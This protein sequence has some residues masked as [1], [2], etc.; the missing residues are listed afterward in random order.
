MFSNRINLHS[1]IQRPKSFRF[2]TT[3]CSWNIQKCTIIKKSVQVKIFLNI[4]LFLKL[5]PRTFASFLS[6]E[7]NTLFPTDVRTY[8]Q[9]SQA[10]LV[11]FL[12]KNCITTWFQVS[13]SEVKG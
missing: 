9:V 13:L 2:R 6:T 7:V 8:K 5:L 4:N 11:V 10:L 12:V 1:F 3:V